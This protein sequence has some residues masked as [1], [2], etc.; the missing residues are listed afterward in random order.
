MLAARIGLEEAV[1]RSLGAVFERWDGKGWPDG[2]AGEEIPLTAR[3][4]N[5]AQDAVNF[6]AQSGLQEAVEVVRR[7]SGHAHDPALVSS[8]CREAAGLMKDLE[9]HGSW[10]EVLEC[11]PKPPH[12]VA[13]E[14]MD[15]ALQAMADFADLK[16]PHT[17]GHSPGVA[18]LGAAAAQLLGLPAGD[19]E[20][21]R[22]AGLLHDLG[23]VGVANGIWEK[24]TRLTETE[25]EQVRLHPYFA[26]RA[27]A[28]CAAL[29]RYGELAATH[30]ERLDGSGYHRGTRAPEIGMSS[31]VLAAADA[32]QAMTE[33]RA[34]RPALD[35]VTAKA[36][37]RDMVA[38]GRLDGQAADAVLAAAGHRVRRTRRDWPAGLSTREVEV[39]RHAVRGASNRQIAERLHIS[40]RTVEH[41]LS[42]AYVKIGVSSRAAA[43]LFAA[44]NDLLQ[45]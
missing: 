29:A 3:I 17:I 24:P 42:H 12:I 28:R 4:V 20:L 44:Q 9:E 7:R 14:R 22:R 32:Y 27:T 41:H 43:A 45:G 33:E 31:R 15:D 39:L 38:A 10:E 2:I 1:Q 13:P 11:D 25:W 35:A 30:H 37:L 34:H 26:E 18:N 6:R 21:V 19:G 36:R 8:F 5:I 23:R 16:D 40:E